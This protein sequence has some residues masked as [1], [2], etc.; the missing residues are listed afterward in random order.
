MNIGL[1]LEALGA[2]FREGDAQKEREYVQKKREYDLSAMP[3]RVAAETAVNRLAAAQAGAEAGLVGDRAEMAKRETQLKSSQLQGELGR[4]PIREQALDAKASEEKSKALLSGKLA[5]VDVNDLPSAILA[6]RSKNLVSEV[7]AK[8]AALSAL[9]SFIGNNDSAGAAH[10]IN[11]IGQIVPEN[12][13]LTSPAVSVGMV[14]MNP[15][16]PSSPKVVI[17]LDANGRPVTKK[18]GSIFQVPLDRIRQS[19]PEKIKDV[20]PGHTV[21]KIGDDGKASHVY[22]A[23]KAGLGEAKATDDI[24][25]MKWLMENG[26][27]KTPQD[28]WTMIRSSREKSKAT[29]IAEYVAKQAGMGFSPEELAV[30]A[31]KAYDAIQQQESRLPTAKQTDPSAAKAAEEKLFGPLGLR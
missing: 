22:T 3:D 18:D 21:I 20:A 26:V 15:D 6:R 28:A 14:P 30:Q 4:A 7:E 2:Y 23:P 12:E 10:F 13:R 9:G 29:F 17:A 16:D 24:Q 31:G 11:R 27:A 8:T 25:N 19:A 5:E 1:G